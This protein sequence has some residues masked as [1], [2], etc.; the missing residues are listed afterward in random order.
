[1]VVQFPRGKHEDGEQI[2]ENTVSYQIYGKFRHGGWICWRG[3]TL[4]MLVRCL[5]QEPLVWQL[6]HVEKERVEYPDASS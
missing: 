4:P 6:I 3:Y 5:F 1:M 2:T